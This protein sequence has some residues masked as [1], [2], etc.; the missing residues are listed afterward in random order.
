MPITEQCLDSNFAR[1]RREAR[2]QLTPRFPGFWA[3]PPPSRE[4]L[5]HTYRSAAAQRLALA[6][7]DYST[8]AVLNV[9]G[10]HYGRRCEFQRNS[11]GQ[12]G[13]TDEAGWTLEHSFTAEAQLGASGPF[14]RRDTVNEA[15][16]YG[17]EESVGHLR[18]HVVGLE[19]LDGVVGLAIPKGLPAVAKAIYRSGEERV[20]VLL[21]CGQLREGIGHDEMVVVGH[22]HERVEIDA[23]ARTRVGEEVLEDARDFWVRSKEVATLGA[24]PRD[25]VGSA[26]KDSTRCGHDQDI[27]RRTRRLQASYQSTCKDNG[28]YP[29]LRP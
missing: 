9:M 1:P 8:Q 28:P 20:E 13:V 16:P 17:V 2:T 22:C 29:V 14:P 21:E 27:D 6:L 12:F 23:V 5:A 26:R 11:I 3:R 15:G 18:Y 25:Q 24:S 19:Q 10:A 4:N 7:L